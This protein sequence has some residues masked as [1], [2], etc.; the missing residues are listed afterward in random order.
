MKYKKL[1]SAGTKWIECEFNPAKK[2][3]QLYN[4]VN[5]KMLP[6]GIGLY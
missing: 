2:R 3:I 5:G 6:D 4:F 1:N